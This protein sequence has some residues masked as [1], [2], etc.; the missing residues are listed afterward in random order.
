M[1]LQIAENILI[2][3]I[4]NG[5]KSAFESI[6]KTYYS[7]LCSYANKF[8]N[9]IDNSEEIVQEIFFQL[10]QKRN[11]LIIQTSF[12]SYLFRS[13]HNSCLNHIKH[14]NIKQKHIE[15]TIYEQD[16]NSQDFI[17]NI[18]T[19]ELQNKIRITIDKL[20]NERKKIFLMIR[21]ENLKYAEVAAKLNISIK[22]VENQMGSALKFMRNELKDYLPI[23][24]F[25]AINF[26]TN[27]LKIE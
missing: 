14:N 11:N 16:N 1:I 12:K 8:V 2:E 4:K 13:V 6:F 15:N 23:I 21:F 9:D 22:T 17:D 24:I 18:E 20:P 26:I 10:W 7:H 27:I 19:N 3:Q 25:L 5:N